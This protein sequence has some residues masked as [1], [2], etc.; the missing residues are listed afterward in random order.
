[1]DIVTWLCRKYN[2]FDMRRNGE[3]DV[4]DWG[5]HETNHFQKAQPMVKNCRNGD[6]RLEHDGE[7][8][9]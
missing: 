9:Y 7:K 1:M 3:L 6:P 2:L 4:A 5:Q 8:H